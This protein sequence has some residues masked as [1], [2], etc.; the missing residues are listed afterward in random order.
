ME[1]G[2]QVLDVTAILPHRFPFIFIDKIIEVTEG[3]TPPS[4]V[5][6]KAICTKNVSWNEDFFNGHFPGR[7]VMPG[8]LVIEAMAQA[9]CVAF[10]RNTDPKIDVAI[11]SIRDARFRRPVVPGDVLRITA[12]IVRDRGQ[13]LVIKCEAHVDNQL[14]AE[15][16]ILAAITLKGH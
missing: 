7:P 12:E 16:E 10:S 1:T 3:P 13:M 5:G 4:R 8:V 14:V 11:A 2:K 15:A 9:G 6:R